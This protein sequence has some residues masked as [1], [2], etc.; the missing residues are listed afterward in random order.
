MYHQYDRSLH[1]RQSILKN[2]LT[3]KESNRE[4]EGTVQA[5]KTKLQNLGVS[6]SPL[7]P[8]TPPRER[9]LPP[10]P[11]SLILGAPLLGRKDVQQDEDEEMFAEEAREDP[12]ALTGGERT[13]EG[14]SATENAYTELPGSFGSRNEPAMVTL[15]FGVAR[16]TC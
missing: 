14:S 1:P 9:S 8:Q 4:L 12:P 7:K 5:L 13:V 3:L 10:R 6:T 16:M 2:V 15:E 11:R